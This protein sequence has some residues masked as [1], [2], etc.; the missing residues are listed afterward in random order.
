MSSYAKSTDINH[1]RTGLKRALAFM[2]S[3]GSKYRPDHGHKI[4]NEEFERLTG[5]KKPIGIKFRQWMGRL[6][7]EGSPFL[8][9]TKSK[10]FKKN[11]AKR[12]RN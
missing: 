4:L 5:L 6:Y 12:K 7:R 10:K 1:C 9:P 8:P 3:K 11:K 2:Y